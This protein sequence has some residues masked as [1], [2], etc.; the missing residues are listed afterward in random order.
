[1]FFPIGDVNLKRGHKPFLTYL[2]LLANVAVFFYQVSLP[3]SLQNQFVYQFGAIPIDILHGHGWLG[4]FTSLFLHGGWMHLLGNM[5]FLWVFADNIEATLG[6]GRFLLF[7]ILGGVIAS[8]VHCIINPYSTIPCVG[9]SGAIAACLGAYL[10][11]FPSS[12][13]KVFF[14]FILSS[15]RVSAV[16]FLG[17]WIIQQFMSGLGSLNP[18]LA[19]SAAVAYWAHIGGFL[20]GVLV[21]GFNR[22]KAKS[23]IE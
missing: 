22:S 18:T 6:Y 7:Y 8:L 11:M 19:E 17:F 5:L 15:F 1:M 21:G 4:L 3:S 23:L 2:I 9:A 12:K 16:F 20:F 13:I 10:I 14:I